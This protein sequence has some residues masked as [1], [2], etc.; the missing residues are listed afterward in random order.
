MNKLSMTALLAVAAGLAACSD[1]VVAPKSE[2]TEAVNVNGGGSMLSLTSSDTIRFS[3]TI[4]PSR[5]TYY[6]L[7]AGNSLTF[8][9]HSLCDP[10]RS[11]YGIGE[12]DKPC[13]QAYSPLTVSVKAWLDSQGHAR[14][15]FSQHVRFVPSNNPAN[16][17]NLTFGDVQASLDPFYNILYCPNV[18]GACMDESKTD[19]TLRVVH[20]PVTGKVT[21]R[22]KHFSGY[23]VSA[24]SDMSEASLTPSDFARFMVAD[25]HANSTYGIKGSG[26]GRREGSSLLSRMM[27]I[28][29]FSGYMLASG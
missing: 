13:N 20:N 2:A 1:G 22:I 18:N 4:D 3:I 17:V 12:W 14:V 24:M 23:N 27:F 15:D 11:S 21:R 25:A 16:W 26:N 6:D 9:A 7:G 19:W 10:T 28:R 8:P 29:R 5:Q